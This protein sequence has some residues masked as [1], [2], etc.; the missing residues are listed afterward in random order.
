MALLGNST[1][2]IY[3]SKLSEFVALIDK[4]YANK[5]IYI[6]NFKL[7]TLI[8]RIIS[9][10]IMNIDFVPISVFSLLIVAPAV[11]A[12]CQ[13]LFEVHAF[14]RPCSF[15]SLPADG[16]HY[17]T[18]AEGKNDN[19]NADNQRRMAPSLREDHVKSAEGTNGVKPHIL[20]P[21]LEEVVSSRAAE[22]ED[23]AQRPNVCREAVPADIGPHLCKNLELLIPGAL[24][25]P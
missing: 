20:P 7:V 15:V 22:H 2:L 17:C 19:N 1:Q 5:L 25:A 16:D 4:F 18:C 10:G 11:R 12:I 6:L 23:A 21:E 24:L 8:V 9:V 14:F 3:I 13:V